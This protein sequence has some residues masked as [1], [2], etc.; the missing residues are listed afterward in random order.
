[1]LRSPTDQ[2]AGYQCW[3]NAYN[4]SDFRTRSEAQAAYRACGGLRADVPRLDGDR[5]GLACDRLR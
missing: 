5:D 3:R 1:M 4:C 2:G